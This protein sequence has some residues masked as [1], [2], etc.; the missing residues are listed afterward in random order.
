MA[1]NIGTVILQS[2]KEKSVTQQQLADF[3]GVSKGAVSKWETGQSFPDITLLPLLAAYF[4]IS[5][6][7]LLSYQTQLTIKQIQQ[8]YQALVDQLERDTSENVL[9][10]VN[11]M[12][13]RYYS[14]APLIFQMGTFLLNHADLL[15]GESKQDKV[16]R[17]F[18][19]ALTL[20]DH[21]VEITNDPQ[22]ISKAKSHAAYCNLSL[23]K[24]DDVL[25]TLGRYVPEYFPNES[26]IAWAYL[27]KGETQQAIATTQ[28]A[29]YQ[30]LA[31]L[32]SQLP[33][34]LQL[35]KDDSI[36]FQQ[37]YQRGVEFIESFNIKQLNQAVTINFLI[38]AAMGFSFQQNSSAALTCLA[39]YTT[40]LE[41]M[42]VPMTLHGDDYFDQVADW[43]AQTETG[44]ALSR[45]SR[46]VPIDCV[47]AVKE[48]PAFMLYQENSDFQQL[49]KRLEKVKE[50]FK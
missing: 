30:Y 32:M 44:N 10:A 47:A 4:N 17:Y 28:S 19:Q 46:Q 3:L 2:R 37:T 14:C 27:A 26:L 49:L 18:N 23:N 5:I 9:L 15:P 35:V 41:T 39:E 34:Y 1:L 40:L 11:N 29:L 8:I 42:P 38:S 20:F 7:S 36:K 6:D 31:V 16:T 43:L 22:L 25:A 45:D 13:H 24:P 50:R 12:I 21:V 48:N 33:N